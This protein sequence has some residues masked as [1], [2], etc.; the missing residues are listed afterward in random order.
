MS[1]KMFDISSVN[2]P[3]NK[4]INWKLVKKSGYV[5]VIIKATEGIDYVNPWLHN[6]V[7]GARSVGLHVGYYHYAHPGHSGAVEQA[8]FVLDKV[9][10]LP[11]DL[12]ISLDLE[13][14][15]LNWEL[16]ANWAQG[17]LATIAAQKITSPIYLNQYYLDNLPGAPFGHKLWIASPSKTP[18]MHHWMWQKAAGPINGIDGVV[19]I[20]EYNG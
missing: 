14:Q 17:F 18:R 10:G 7:S 11:R 4:P 15:E 2:H 9:K 3:N 6:D 20:D 1:L 16:T 19:D 12:G 5:G 8:N 13:V